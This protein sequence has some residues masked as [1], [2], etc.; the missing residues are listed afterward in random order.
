MG[1]LFKKPSFL[2]GVAVLCLL[3]TVVL[4]T[5]RPAVAAAANLSMTPTGV[6]VAAR[7][8]TPTLTSTAT[9]TRTSTPTKTPSPIPTQTQPPL[10]SSTASA[11]MAPT[12]T[13]VP[14]TAKV[15]TLTPVPDSPTA[16]PVVKL[17]ASVRTTP[18]SEPTVALTAAPIA[19]TVAARKPDYVH[20]RTK[21][22]ND[23]LVFVPE[24]GECWLA[25]LA[26]P[27][28]LYSGVGSALTPCTQ[29][30]L[31]PGIE[32]LETGESYTN[33]GEMT[34]Y[35][36]VSRDNRLKFSGITAEKDGATYYQVVPIKTTETGVYW[37]KKE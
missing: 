17:V 18:V 31:E 8:V 32:Y 25:F 34:P 35:H 24:P 5:K 1:N 12:Q 21:T 13:R 9:A 7:V 16:V 6:M 36:V 26:V 11:T 15:N 2:L 19:Q 30:Y 3:S 27:S 22:K 10:P 37:V 4:G 14:A 29:V 33:P 20:P 23:A 28:W